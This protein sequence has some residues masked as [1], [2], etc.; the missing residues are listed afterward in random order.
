[1]KSTY[2]IIIAAAVVLLLVIAYALTRASAA[3]TSG[4]PA[5]ETGA[6]LPP[7]PGWSSRADYERITAILPPVTTPIT[8]ELDDAIARAKAVGHF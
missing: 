3:A 2:A 7:P 6:N 5:I 4:Q 8:S 1:M